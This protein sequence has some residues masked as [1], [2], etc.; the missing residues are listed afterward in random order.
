[1]PKLSALGGEFH[2]RKKET[3]RGNTAGR[4]WTTRCAGVGDA[5]GLPVMISEWCV[6]GTVYFRD[7]EAMVTSFF[8]SRPWH[9]LSQGKARHWKVT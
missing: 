3:R 8:K 6:A 5:R 9:P 7:L 2:K 4:A 1:V